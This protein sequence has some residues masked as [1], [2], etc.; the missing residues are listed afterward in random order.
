[1]TDL[2]TIN[3]LRRLIQCDLELEARSG[4]VARERAFNLR[5]AEHQSNT[6]A[7]KRLVAGTLR[8]GALAIATARDEALQGHPQRRAQ[9]VEVIR[10]MDAD[11][12]A[13]LTAKALVD[14]ATRVR[15]LTAVAVALGEMI[16]SEERMARFHAVNPH[17]FDWTLQRATRDSAGGRAAQLGI[18]W[19]LMRLKG[20]PYTPWG[21]RK[22]LFVGLWLIDQ[23]N[24]A[25]GLFE[26]ISGAVE[27]GG[28]VAHF[29]QPKPETEEWLR[30]A[31]ARAEMHV[32]DYWPMVCEPQPWTR[33][34]GGGYL[35][36]VIPTLPLVKSR[37]GPDGRAHF[38]ALKAAD[39]TGVIE[40]V[41]LA[42]STAWR[43]NPDVLA[44][45]EKL[46]AR[47]AL[48]N[49]G[50]DSEQ[51]IPERPPEAD[52]DDSARKSWRKVASAAH[53]AN[54]K[55]RA[56]RLEF[57]RMLSQARRFGAFDAI[58][59]PQQLDFRGRMYSV[60]AG[61]NPQG[62]D[63]QKSLLRFSIGTPIN[64][65]AALEW[66]AIHGANSYGVDKVPFVDRWNWVVDNLDAIRATAEDPEG[67]AYDFWIKADSPLCFFAWACDFIR[68]IDG[69]WGTVS[70][71]P[72][73]MDGSCNGIQHYSA[74]LRDPVGGKQVNLI[75]SDRPA[76]IYAEVARRTIAAITPLKDVSGNDGALARA[77]LRFGIDRKITKRS[78][79]TLPYGCTNFSVREF[80]DD[81][82]REKLAGGAVNEFE[83]VVEGTMRPDGIFDAS[84]WL[85]SHVWRCIGDTVVAARGGMDYLQTLAGQLAKHGGV[86]E[87]ETPDGFPVRQAYRKIIS[88]QV[89]TKFHGK[90]I[91]PRLD[92]ETEELDRHRQRNGVAPNW[93][94]SMDGTA[95]RLFVRT[96][97]AAGLDQFALIHD[98]FG[99]PAGNA[100]VAAWALRDSF[101]RLYEEADPVATYTDSVRAALP[102][103]AL[104]D[105]PMPPPRGTLDLGKVRDSL[106]AFA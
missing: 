44:L 1:M 26:T 49:L 39:L 24:R 31:A 33:P 104:E 45:L 74:A 41:N 103:E 89:E 73:A 7:G 10:E 51:P 32:A 106:Y 83:G 92:E 84:K 87:W 76:D 53:V 67:P 102:P 3:A 63:L 38:D 80:I 91:K 94:H 72:V 6:H 21:A 25:T 77:W 27:G 16:E 5:N 23:F 60:P 50:Y 99:V 2:D 100:A 52:E 4:A 64:D 22:R 20:V 18:V 15:P 34:W 97:A 61:V 59:F 66:L 65:E 19:R 78:V 17:A 28:K 54:R 37:G 58:W 81:A 96:A 79:M 70:Y 47:D 57:D 105:L 11:V 12:L 93:V 82:I 75:P 13:L 88:R 55:R 42:Q 101:A 48:D 62:N 95:L 30:E 36:K 9:A 14:G 68:V 56:R 71:V 98:S 43:I 69:G 85:A 29:L 8:Q 86:V 90:V 35:T 46:A 40:A